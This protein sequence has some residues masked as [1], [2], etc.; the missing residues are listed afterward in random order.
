MG[1]IAVGSQ[2]GKHKRHPTAKRPKRGEMRRTWD[3]SWGTAEKVS[4]GPWPW[5]GCPCSISSPQVWDNGHGMMMASLIERTMIDKISGLK[6]KQI[7]Q[8]IILLITTAAHK[9]KHLRLAPRASNH[10]P[11]L[12]NVPELGILRIVSN[13]SPQ[14]HQQSRHTLLSVKSS[15]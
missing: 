11:L 14:D 10:N 6:K 9:A 3:G 2:R 5:L 12:H 4:K 13:G 7:S 1:S 8:P 15:S